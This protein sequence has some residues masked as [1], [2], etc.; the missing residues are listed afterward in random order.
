MNY[1]AVKN[2]LKALKNC[3]SI[4]I[5]SDIQKESDETITLKKINSEIRKKRQLRLLILKSFRNDLEKFI[6]RDDP[7]ISFDERKLFENGY[8]AID[9]LEN[10]KVSHCLFQDDGNINSAFNFYS[11]NMTRVIEN[12]KPY[13]RNIMD[14]EKE[15]S[16]LGNNFYDYI[17]AIVSTSLSNFRFV[18]SGD[19]VNISKSDLLNASLTTD[20]YDKIMHYFAYH[21]RRILEKILVYDDTSLDTYRTNLSKDKALAI[22]RGQK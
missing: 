12:I 16:L 6:R 9:F 2:N 5:L 11:T 17:Y 19:G 10:D 14:F 22:Y 20:E 21:Y 7:S 13:I 15:T 4:A 18:I 8:L 3:S 1:D